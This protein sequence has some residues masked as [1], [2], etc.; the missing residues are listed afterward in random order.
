VKFSARLLVCLLAN[1]A[2]YSQ[3]N[4][5]DPIPAHPWNQLYA[6]LHADPLSQP[7]LNDPAQARALL[8]VSGDEYDT[9]LKQLDA[10]IANNSHK[11]VASPVKRAILQSTLWALFDQVSDANGED[12][13]NRKSLADRCARIIRRLALS[14]AELAALPDNFATAIK[15]KEFAA[16]YDPEHREHAFL[17]P[18]LFDSTNGP[19]VMMAGSDSQ[20]PAAIRHV[21]F[22]QGR[23]VFYVLVRLPEGRAATVAYLRE[24]ANFP[25]PYVWNEMYAPYPYARPVTLPNPEL[26]QFP[27]GTQVALVRRMMLTDKAGNLVVTPII[28]SVQLRVYRID[29]KSVKPFESDTQDFYDLRLEPKLLFTGTSGL[30]K[31]DIS[32]RDAAIRFPR[33]SMFEVGFL[34]GG[35]HNCHG[36][37]GVLSL[38][39]YAR[40]FGPR[41]MS[42]WFE[43]SMEPSQDDITA[44]WKK[45][46]YT[47]GLLTGLMGAH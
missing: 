18:D 22:T 47:W 8:S 32:Q 28:E 45:R 33:R 42:P 29:P 24:L 36:E 13:A 20:R 1:S 19:W 3:S 11:S 14:E 41:S 46:D 12:Q 26:P 44:K 23:S 38:Q 39:T 37:T 10:F 2:A 27:A 30:R 17:P 15:S 25:R 21:E 34:M 35:C 9:V 16:A 40:R 5:F 43:P 4:V 31:H 6:A 7:F